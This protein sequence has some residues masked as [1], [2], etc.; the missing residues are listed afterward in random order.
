M[1]SKFGNSS[2]SLREVIITLIL[3]EFNQKTSILR[4][5]LGLSSVIWDRH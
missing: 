4:D 5:A 2:I 3:E 1:W